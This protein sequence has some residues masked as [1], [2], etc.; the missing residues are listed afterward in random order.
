MRDSTEDPEFHNP[1][2]NFEDIN[3]IESLSPGNH[4][5]GSSDSDEVSGTII[6]TPRPQFQNPMAAEPIRS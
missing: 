6:V 5:G 1:R 4:R 2:G 3:L